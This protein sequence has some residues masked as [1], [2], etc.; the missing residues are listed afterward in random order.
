MALLV[1]VVLIGCGRL[2]PEYDDSFDDFL[3]DEGQVISPEQ[4][5]HIRAYHERLLQDLDIHFKVVIPEESP[6]DIGKTAVQ[7]FEN[8]SLGNRTRGVKGLLLIVDPQGQQTR[9]ETGYDLE[10]IFT[11]AFVGYIQREQMA[12]FYN[13]GRVGEGI[14]ATVELLVTRVSNAIDSSE[15]DPRAEQAPAQHF[16]GGAGAS[17]QL[18][19][20]EL[21]ADPLPA[22]AAEFMGPQSSVD[23]AFLVYVQILG[24]RVKDPH[25]GVY[26]PETQDFLE[27]QLVTDAQQGNE[28]AEIRAVIDRRTVVEHGDLAVMRFQGSRR[29]PPYF[30]RRRGAAWV[31][32]LFATRRVIGFD[33]LNQWYVR[34]SQSEFSFGL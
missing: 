10:P 13:S 6:R 7:M 22:A 15:Y 18:V 30:F 29:V 32:D 33:Q 21:E 3:I 20:T 27:K 23:A 2:Q 25:L 5:K 19:A 24:K 12:P 1:L 14:E 28:L 4:A 26:S 8:Y 17:T 9:I 16:S 11:D 31:I 34:D